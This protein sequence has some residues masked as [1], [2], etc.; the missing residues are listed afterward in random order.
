MRVSGWLDPVR[1]AL[2]S[3]EAPVTVFC[4]DDDAGWDDAALARFLGAVADAGATVDVAAIPVETGA[5]T[6]A[7]LRPFLRDGV[8]RV[9]QHGFAHVNHEPEGRKIEF[10]PSRPRAQQHADV[11]DGRARLLDAFGGALEPVFTPPWNR[12]TLDTA[13]VLRDLGVLVLSR[14]SGAA[15]FDLPGLAEVP[16]TLDWTAHRRKVP[17]TPAEWA[18]ELAAQLRFGG[19]VGL[20]FHHAPLAPEELPAVGE[21][22]ALLWSSP[23][24]RG[25]SIASAVGALTRRRPAGEPAGRPSDG[26]EAHLPG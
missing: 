4:R 15:P 26:V 16:V 3:L 2:D 12:C 20:M 24:V 17:L 9:H 11:A 13:T 19:P 6:V 22:L 21:V 7:T 5:S 8:A 1:A 25:A 23:S 14:E 10:G 18:D